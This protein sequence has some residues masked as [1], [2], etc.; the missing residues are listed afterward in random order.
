M[1]FVLENL[2]IKRPRRLSAK[3]RAA[4]LLSIALIKTKWDMFDNETRIRAAK[5]IRCL[6]TQGFFR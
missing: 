4:N 1:M 5:T 2:E 3:D 6:E